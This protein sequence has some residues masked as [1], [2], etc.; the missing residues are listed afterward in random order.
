[1]VY[2]ASGSWTDDY[3]L[4]MLTADMKSDVLKPTSWVKASKPGF[5]STN[6]V[7]D[8][9]HNSFATSP[10]GKEDWIVYHVARFS[11]AGWNRNIRKQNFTWNEDGLPNFGSSVKVELKAG[12]NV[13]RLDGADG[14]DEVDCFDIVPIT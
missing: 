11:K 14:E 1:M 9:G 12:K 10:D 5:S 6:G 4:G 3:C 2:S 13:L 8:P 7:F